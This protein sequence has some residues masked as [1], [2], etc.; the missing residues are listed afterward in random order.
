MLQHPMEY[1]QLNDSWLIKYVALEFDG[2]LKIGLD[3]SQQRNRLYKVG[4]LWLYT[5]SQV[6]RRRNKAMD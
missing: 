5:L 4:I 6:R 3:I 2:K 1:G